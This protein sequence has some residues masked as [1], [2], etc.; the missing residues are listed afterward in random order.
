[1][2]DG[3]DQGLCVV[4]VGAEGK[5]LRDKTPGASLRT[6]LPRL[7]SHRGTEG[8]Q[9]PP[10]ALFTTLSWGHQSQPLPGPGGVLVPT[11]PGLPRPSSLQLTLVVIGDVV[12]G[13]SVDE[14]GRQAQRLVGLV[15][16]AD[17]VV[18]WEG[19]RARWLRPDR[20]PHT[21]PPTLPRAQVASPERMAETG[22]I[23]CPTNLP[24]SSKAAMRSE[25]SV[26]STT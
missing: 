7:W 17:V 9:N 2:L 10:S 11:L 1:M 5:G 4:W 18:P 25:A 12:R 21:L 14:Q 24:P 23:R 6:S 13:L 22:R 26:G 20:S 3:I 15:P 19:G 16:Q 8:A